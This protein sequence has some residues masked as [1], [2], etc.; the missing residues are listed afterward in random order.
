MVAIL[1]TEQTLLLA[2]PNRA[3]TYSEDSERPLATPTIESWIRSNF[4]PTR[5]GR[6]SSAQSAQKF[7]TY[8]LSTLA[9]SFLY[10]VAVHHPIKPAQNIKYSKNAKMIQ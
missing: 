3:H 6:E 5:V 10:S 9:A 8:N 2:M 4:F 7:K 1:L